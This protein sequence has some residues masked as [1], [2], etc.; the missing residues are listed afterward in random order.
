MAAGAAAMAGISGVATGFQDA[1]KGNALRISICQ[2]HEATEK[3]KT[4]YN[5]VLTAQT[6][7]LNNAKQDLENALSSYG[8]ISEQLSL[9]HQAYVF[10][11]GQIVIGGIIFT[12]ILVLLLLFKYFDLYKLIFNA[13]FK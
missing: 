10:Q 12:S 11:H 2:T 3:L 4:K 13:I 9:A 6:T 8:K 1:S 5:A 7:E